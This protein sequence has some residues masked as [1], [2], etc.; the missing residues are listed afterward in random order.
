M[1]EI[2]RLNTVIIFC[3]WRVR[4]KKLKC[5]GALMKDGSV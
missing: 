3:F 5:A 4:G 1:K 2:I